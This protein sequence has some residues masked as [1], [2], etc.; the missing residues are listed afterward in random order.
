MDIER[1]KSILNILAD[2]INPVT[3]EVLSSEDSCNQ[4]EVVR[5]LNTILRTV[6]IQQISLA[7]QK[8]QNAGKPWTE[9]EEFELSKMFD[10]GRT[11]KEI[12]EYFKRTDGAI[13]ARLVKL[14]KICERDEFR[15][16]P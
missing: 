12:C 8:R 2:G 14:G 7:K 1:A 3:G 10:E 15:V 13:A 11:R 4:V 9:K 5:A 16:R 6:E